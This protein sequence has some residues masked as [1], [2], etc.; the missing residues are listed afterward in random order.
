MW[1]HVFQDVNHGMVSSREFNRFQALDART[2]GSMLLGGTGRQSK[3]EQEF[4]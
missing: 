2:G 1:A 4:G 3:D